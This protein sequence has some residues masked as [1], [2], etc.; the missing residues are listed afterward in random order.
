MLKVILGSN[1]FY[2]RKRLRDSLNPGIQ[3]KLTNWIKYQLF[4]SSQKYN[5][6]ER[7]YLSHQ[8]VEYFVSFASIFALSV[9]AWFVS[10]L[11]FALVLHITVSIDA[12]NSSLAHIYLFFVVGVGLLLFHLIY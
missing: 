2:N 9:D 3:E 1:T 10:V 8:L 12:F 11:F 4:C 7:P 5:R 6:E